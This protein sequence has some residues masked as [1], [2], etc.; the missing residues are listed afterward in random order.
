MLVKLPKPLAMQLS[1]N[2]QKANNFTR[3]VFDLLTGSEG[4][5]VEVIMDESSLVPTQ[6][7]MAQRYRIPR[8]SVGFEKGILIKKNRQIRSLQLQRFYHTFNDFFRVTKYHHC[9]IHIK[10]IVI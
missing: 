8:C 2:P 5:A 7:H 10:Q 3:A 4:G 9:F 1:S 6:A